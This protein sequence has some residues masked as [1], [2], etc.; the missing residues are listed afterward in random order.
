M[1]RR[2]LNLVTENLD[3]GL[4]SLRR[5]NLSSHLFCPS[6]AAAEAAM[7][8][9]EAAIHANAER[10]VGYKHGLRFLQ[11]IS[12]SLG[13]LPDAE[14][15][16]KP[17]CPYYTRELPFVVVTLLGDESKIFCSDCLG[18]TSLYDIDSCAVMTVPNLPIPISITRAAADG[19]PA[20]QRDRLYIIDR[21]LHSDFGDDC[22]EELIYKRGQ[23]FLS[24]KDMFN[25]WCSL[26]PPADELR[27]IDA[28]TVVGDSTIYVSS[29]TP[30][31]GTYAFDTESWNWW[32]AG[33]WGLPFSGKAEYVP[34]LNL[35]FGLSASRPFHLCAYDLSAVNFERPPM[36]CH[37]W[38]DLDMPK[39]WSPLEM[40]LINL[41]SSRFC[42]V[43]RCNGEV[44]P[45]GK[46]RMLKN[47]SKYHVFEDHSI[48]C[49]L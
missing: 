35:W 20:G 16:L 15:N 14:I 41:G 22:F 13:T 31:V 30:S 8:R 36:V 1:N 49:V 32:H 5:L 18:C 45:P 19:S 33:E 28:H 25:G 11:T 29:T 21:H 39:S 47:M 38:V 43:V 40:D 7:A 12:S 2:F 10:E 23:Y 9:S 4:H 27:D 37:A 44:S 24:V 48:K 46:L 34:E 3:T 6:T 17:G 42:V 26:P